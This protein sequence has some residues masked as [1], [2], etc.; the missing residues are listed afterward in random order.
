MKKFFE[1]PSVEVIAFA[2]EDVITASGDPE[3]EEDM[4]AF[5]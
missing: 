5:G 3:A 4:T 1:E 2:V